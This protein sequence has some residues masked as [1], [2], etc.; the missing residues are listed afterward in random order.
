MRI[1]SSLVGRYVSQVL[2]LVVALLLFAGTTYAQDEAAP[3]TTVSVPAERQSPR[4]T[5]RTFLRSMIEADQTDDPRTRDKLIQKAVGTLDLTGLPLTAQ[6]TQGPSLA[7]DLK[8]KVLDK[9]VFID[10]DTIPDY[11]SGPSY[12]VLEAPSGRVVEIGKTDQGDWKFTKQSVDNIGPLSREFS[13]RS[14]VQDAIELRSIKPAGEVLRD[15]LPDWLKRPAFFLYIYQWIGIALLAIASLIIGRVLSTVVVSVILS[16]LKKW[17]RSDERK[18]AVNL[19]WPMG[20]ALSTIVWWAFSGWLDLP[21]D[22]LKFVE[23]IVIIL[24]GISLIVFLMR[25]VDLVSLR[26]TEWA[27]KSENKYDDLL[28]PFARK[29]SKI[30]VFIVGGMMVLQALGMD[31]AAALGTLAI[32]GLA[33]SLAAKDTIS[34][35]F[36]TITIIGDRP[37]QIGDWVVTEGV[38]GTVE[39]L[40][41]RSTRIRTFYNSLI[42]VPNGNLTNAVVDN[43]GM[44]QYRRYRTHVSL[45]Y[46]TPPEKMEAFCEAVRELIRNHPYTRKD[47]FHVY[48]HGYSA[49]SLDVLVYIFFE[50]PDWGTELR[51]RHR[52]NLDVFRLAKQIGVDFAFPTQ[53][54]HMFQEDHDR[55]LPKSE[56]V[57]AS[58]IDEEIAKARMGTHSMME[59]TLGP[60]GTVPPPVT[61]SELEP[62]SAAS[63]DG[64]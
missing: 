45:T 8:S 30:V 42:T 39:S 52:F 46:S 60:R 58:E 35:V 26:M 11:L 28:V 15:S 5:M 25:L 62:G 3:D 7:Y 16:R 18:H 49:S 20:F 43:Y 21:V 17:F 32:G 59:K 31:L 19:V 54:L 12:V 13:N 33:V 44:R 64:D 47:Y 22:V 61:F 1:P 48:F 10:Y 14:I 55:E 23:Y 6:T 63:A 36:G 51:E 53:T 9:S 56:I 40:G 57:T 37:F 38:E 41:F 24:F 2:L 29:V 4:D 50:T 34:N 27:D